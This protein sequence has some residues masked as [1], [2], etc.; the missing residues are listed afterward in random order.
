M[1]PYIWMNPVCFEC[2]ICFD[3]PPVCL[4]AP[5]FSGCTPCM[6]GCP[7]VWMFG[8][9]LYVWIMFGCPPYIHNTK[10]AFFVTLKECPYAPIHL[11][12]PCMYGFPSCLDTFHMFGCPMFEYPVVCLGDVWMPPCTYTRHRKHAMSH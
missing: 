10:K 7:H 8:H 12:A 5:I 4:D 1:S 2:P 9:P 6:F 3:A 11:D